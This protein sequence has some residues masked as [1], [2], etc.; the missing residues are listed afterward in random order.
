MFALLKNEK[1]FG[2][3][4][5]SYENA[6]EEGFEPPDGF[7][8]SVFKTDAFGHSATLPK[9][10]IIYK[11]V[12]VIFQEQA[13]YLKHKKKHLKLTQKTQIILMK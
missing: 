1:L 12:L 2:I 10:S 4:R 5:V 9:K 3:L 7:P 8:S 13:I 11:V 6:E